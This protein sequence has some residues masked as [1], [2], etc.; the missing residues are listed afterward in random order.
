MYRQ[1]LNYST[2]IENINK[3]ILIINCLLDL[4][5]TG[6]GKYYKNIL[7]R[8]KQGEN[9]IEIQNIIDRLDA[10]YQKEYYK[11]EKQDIDK[12]NINNYNFI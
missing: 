6:Y 10:L 2:N 11:N 4:D 3:N 12:N 7:E 8:Y 1:I 5:K 9:T